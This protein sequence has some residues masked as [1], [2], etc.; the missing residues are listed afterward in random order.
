[1]SKVRVYEVAKQL[2]VDEPTA[3]LLLQRQGA[4]VRNR[5]SAVEQDVADR[6]RRAFERTEI[7]P[8]LAAAEERKISS[9]SST[10]HRPVMPGFYMNFNLRKVET[11]A[12]GFGF[13]GGL[14]KQALL[15]DLLHSGQLHVE[16]SHD[17]RDPKKTVWYCRG[18]KV[19]IA[20]VPDA[21]LE[22]TLFCIGVVQGPEAA[23]PP[24]RARVFAV[25]GPW[26]VHAFSRRPPPPLTVEEHLI[27]CSEDVPVARRQPEPTPPVGPEQVAVK[28]DLSPIQ[29][30]APATEIVAKEESVPLATVLSADSDVAVPADLEDPLRSYADQSDWA[31]LALAV[32]TDSNAD[33]AG[34]VGAQD[35]IDARR[36]RIARLE[37][38]IARLQANL[39][40]VPEEARLLDAED[41]R[42]EIADLCAR[43][44][45]VPP[46]RVV[47]R[48]P[49][50]LVATLRDVLDEA[51]EHLPPWATG[52]D[53]DRRVL[54]GEESAQ[55]RLRVAL[56]WVR[57][58]F[59]GAPPE[60]LR[61]V[62]AVEGSEPIDAR[63]EA[64]WRQEEIGHSPKGSQSGGMPSP[65]R[66]S[67]TCCGSRLQETFGQ[68]QQHLLSSWTC[69]RPTWKSS[70][71]CERSRKSCA[72]SKPGLNRSSHSSPR[73]GK[74]LNA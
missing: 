70:R 49:R 67:T 15:T 6:A 11:L 20:C 47:T 56:D 63:L 33:L 1:M 35:P 14:W 38:D 37:A 26:S 31:A 45:G 55:M 8:P 64:A 13:W 24:A 61:K 29:P 41:M 48:G 46:S 54:L 43:L 28:C 27:K 53:G 7:P 17:P 52:V 44:G 71:I 2:G 42:Q 73:P 69:R 36:Q 34:L 72:S 57:R 3:L 12:A 66:H 30:P 68:L 18:R 10:H 32:I 19:S 51:A 58:T 60:R 23:G 59:A 5:L 9:T 16:R 21:N 4:S 62:A 74:P 50:A 25:P 65:P 39:L 22:D 40:A